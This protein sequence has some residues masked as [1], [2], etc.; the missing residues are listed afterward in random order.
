MC[1]NYCISENLRTLGK[2]PLISYKYALIHFLFFL[3]TGQERE[4]EKEM[5]EEIEGNYGMV[6]ERALEWQRGPPTNIV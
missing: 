6:E 1:N 4:T 2:L 3:T 5:G